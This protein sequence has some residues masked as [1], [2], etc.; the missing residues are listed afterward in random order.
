MNINVANV[1]YRKNDAQVSV[2][3]PRLGS[4]LL[5]EVFVVDADENSNIT[6]CNE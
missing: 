1:I 2:S 4:L 3:T 5:N 6:G